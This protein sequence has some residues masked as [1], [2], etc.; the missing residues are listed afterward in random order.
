M[1]S[2]GR[3]LQSIGLGIMAL[4]LT[5]APA[6]AQWTRVTQVPVTQLFSLRSVG[7]TIAAGADTAVYLSTNQGVSWLRS[8]KPAA[9]VASIQAVLMRNGRLYAGTYGQGVRVSDNLGAT[10]QAY[11]QGLVGGI[12]D[13][14]LFIVDLEVRGNDLFAATA[15]AGVYVRSLTEPSTWQHF[16]EE[17]EPNQASNLNS[18]TLGANRLLATA[19]SNGMV[20]RRDPGESDWTVSFLDNVGIHAGL[21]AFDAIYTGTIWV[22]GSGNGLFRSVAGQEPWTRLDP[23]ISPMTWTTF[24]SQGQHLFAAFDTPILAVVAESDDDLGSFQSEEV[25]PNV[26]I[27][28]LALEGG[29]LYAAR[30]DGLWRRPSGLVSVPAA[31]GPARLRLA[32][33]GPQPFRDQT[34]LRFELPAAGNATIEVL[35]IAGRRAGERIEGWWSAGPHEVALDAQGMSPGIYAAVLTSGAERES[36]RLVHVR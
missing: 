20:F 3:T 24:A 18:L 6:S 27:K 31:G 19:G 33:A 29:S 17:F 12:L 23:G 8:A 25:F 1:K 15:G 2:R 4:G 21:Q 35:D 30:G 11:N 36:V 16:G 22:V 34:R 13:T 10:W 32:L 7:D 28:G 5:A 26:F 9:G 14:Q